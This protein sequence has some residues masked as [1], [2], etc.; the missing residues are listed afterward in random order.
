VADALTPLA[1]FC[2]L[3]VALPNGLAELPEV[4]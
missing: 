1:M 2:A 4:P 3:D